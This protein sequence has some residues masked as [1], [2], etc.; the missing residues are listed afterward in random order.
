MLREI[1][2]T[3]ILL[4][5]MIPACSERPPIP[6]KDFVDLYVQLHLLDAQYG[7]QPAVQKLKADS[8]MHAFNV[9][10]S[11]VKAALTWY[12]QDPERW[13]GFF[14]DVQERMKAV[15]KIYLK[16]P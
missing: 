15:R 4:T 10:D 8:L 6:Q 11:L 3:L 16:K 7:S 1:T 13:Q 2:K 5:L 9:N 14:S 12:G